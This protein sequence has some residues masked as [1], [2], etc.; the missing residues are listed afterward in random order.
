MGV[1][2]KPRLAGVTRRA[3]KRTPGSYVN[4]KTASSN[5]T[6]CPH[7]RKCNTIASANSQIVIDGSRATYN[8]VGGRRDN[9]TQTNQLMGDLIRAQHSIHASGFNRADG[10]AW[11]AR[12]S[13]IL[14]KC[15][16]T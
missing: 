16:A 3:K 6:S 2:W 14:G 15:G 7:D 4:R 9:P 5:P 11:K 12:R 8:I 10:H 13:R 1:A